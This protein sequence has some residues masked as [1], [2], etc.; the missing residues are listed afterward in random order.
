MGVTES[1]LG[2][3]GAVCVAYG[4][5]D[6]V[7]NT[8]KVI[9]L[10]V[11][12]ILIGLSVIIIV[13]KLW[14][15]ERNH[16]RFEASY[17]SCIGNLAATA[18]TPMAETTIAPA[19]AT[20]STTTTTSAT[21]V[22]P[23]V[24]GYDK[25]GFHVQSSLHRPHRLISSHHRHHHHNSSVPRRFGGEESDHTGMIQSTE[26]DHNNGSAMAKPMDFIRVP[27][28]GAAMASF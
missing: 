18:N 3:G 9:L 25:N 10:L 4:A 22:V 28:M 8:W 20:T 27:M 24:G 19:V 17:K 11:G 13:N 5:S 6:R 15:C 23:V 21:P 12:I 14:M 1:V 7:G 16:A 2:L 26:F